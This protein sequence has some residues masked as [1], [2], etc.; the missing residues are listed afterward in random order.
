MCGSNFYESDVTLLDVI[1]LFENGGFEYP[2]ISSI[3][4]VKTVKIEIF[5]IGSLNR[6]IKLV[7][8][9]KKMK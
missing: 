4:L 1:K 3:L 2:R 8:T 6:N 5:R 7:V 9:Y